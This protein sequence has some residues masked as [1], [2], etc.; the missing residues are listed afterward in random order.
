MFLNFASI[1]VICFVGLKIIKELYFQTALFGINSFSEKD[2]VYVSWLSKPHWVVRSQSSGSCSQVSHKTQQQERLK[3]VFSLQ[4]HQG[5]YAGEAEMPSCNSNVF[6]DCCYQFL[7]WE[8]DIK[9][10]LSISTKEPFFTP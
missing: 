3:A 5:I 8:E 1:V 6:H 2:S 4:S 10:C 7:N 9:A